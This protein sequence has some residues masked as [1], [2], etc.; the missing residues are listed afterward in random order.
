[1]PALDPAEEDIVLTKTL[2]YSYKEANKQAIPELFEEQFTLEDLG[3][4]DRQAL[5]V[6]EVLTDRAKK[7]IND[8]YI[9]EATT[10]QSNFDEETKSP[11][12]RLKD[13]SLLRS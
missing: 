5:I 10:Q 6:S 7:I 12:I 1:M 11:S 8:A 3:I 4:M 13:S 2:I 9:E